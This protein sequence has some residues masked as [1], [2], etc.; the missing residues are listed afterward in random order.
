MKYL[1]TMVRVTDQDPYPATAWV[2]HPNTPELDL[3]TTISDYGV[4]EIYS[5]NTPL[6]P[7]SD[8]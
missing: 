6:E 4:R 5:V 3:T 8:G 7:V 2:P 1:H